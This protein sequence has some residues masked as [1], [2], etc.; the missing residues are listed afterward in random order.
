M[1][2]MEQ[3]SFMDNIIGD[4]ISNSIILLKLIKN[5]IKPNT[6]IDVQDLEE[7]LTNA[8]LKNYDNN[9]LTFT[10]EMKK[11]FKEIKCLSFLTAFLH[12]FYECT[13]KMMKDKWIM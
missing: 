13:V 8:T 9:I 6:V 10:H 4:E 1:A 3:F 2:E 7:N 11:I 12:E 5:D